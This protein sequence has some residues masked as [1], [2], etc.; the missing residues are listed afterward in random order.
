MKKSSGLQRT[1][2]MSAMIDRKKRPLEPSSQAARA[3][4]REYVEAHGGDTPIHT[5]LIANNG[6]AATKAMLSLREFAFDVLG[7]SKALC[8]VAMASGQ[9]LDANAEFVRLAD[10]VVEVPSG[11]NKNNYANVELIIDVAEREAVDAVWPG[12]GHASEYP[13]LP[14][15]LAKRNIA[16]IGPSGG[17]MRALGDKIAASILA[18]TARV[19]SIPWSGD[20]ITCD[21]KVVI[22]T[23]SIPPELFRKAMVTTA[24]EC[25]KAA[26]R[27]GYPV[28]LK[29][30]EGGGGKG[31]RM[32]Q[33]AQELRM[34]FVQVSNEVPGSPM[35]LMQLC[36]N[37]RHL[38]VQ[39]VG[40][41][42][43][44]AV[45]LNGRDCSTQRRFQKIFE[46][47]PAA[48]A[49][50][51]VFREMELAAM[52]LTQSIGYSGAG[53]VEYLY[54]AQTKKYYFLELNPRL[55]VEHPCTEGITD[56][57]MPAA[58][59]QVAMGIPLHRIPHIR[60][61]YGLEDVHGSSP[62]DFHVQRYPK[63]TKHI[64]AAR[65]TAENPDEGFKPTSGS[66]ERC[67]FQSN[68]NVWGYFSVGANGGIHE[69]ADSQFGH[70]FA[71][72]ATREI[73][74][75]HL[76]LALKSVE[77]RGAIRNPVEYLVELLESDA[78]KQNEIH[79]GWLDG[80][81]KAKSIAVPT[82]TPRLVLAAVLY[83]SHTFV[84]SKR[85]ELEAS[86][87]KGQLSTVLVKDLTAFAQTITYEG[88]KYDFHVAK[89]G[90]E[91]FSL[92]LNGQTIHAKVREQPD[93]SL[94][95][96]FGGATRKV[97]GLEEPLG[98]R[99]SCDGV[100]CL[101]PT[102]FDPSELRT[103]V[104]GKVVRYL[105]EEGAHLGAGQPYVE[106]EAMKM[107]MAL[108]TVESG[109]CFPA[110][111]SGS[112]ISAGD[113]LATLVLSDPSK[114]AKVIP[115]DGTLDDVL[116]A[117]DEDET[118]A[119]KCA[120][121]LD[122]YQR[123]DP[124][125]LAKE[126]TD[127]NVNVVVDEAAHLLQRYLVVESRYAGRPM[128]AVVQE[129][130]AEHKEDLGKAIDVARA[131]SQL[132][133]RTLLCQQVLKELLQLYA[134]RRAS[135]VDAAPMRLVSALA[136]LAA[137]PGDA[138]GD[139]A[140]LALRVSLVA[141]DEAPTPRTLDTRLF[142]KDSLTRG[143]ALI[144][145]ETGSS[146]ATA[147]LGN[148]AE[149]SQLTKPGRGGEPPVVFVFF[150]AAS[151]CFSGAKTVQAALE[152]VLE[153][154]AL[155]RRDAKVP[156][157]SSSS[158]VLRFPGGWGHAHPEDG[159]KALDAA[160]FGVA[161]RLASLHV[162]AL[163]VRVGSQDLSLAP[164]TSTDWPTFKSV[165]RGEADV[166]T[167]S[168]LAKRRA[169]ARRA[170]STFCYDFIG[171]FAREVRSGGGDAFV[172]DELVWEND[173]EDALTTSTRTPGLNDCGMVAWHCAAATREYPE[174]REFV[175]VANDV[176]FQSGSFGV[177]EDT[178]YAKASQ[179]ARSQ[180]L[181]Q[182]Y[183][184]CNS[185]ARIGLA[186]ELKPKFRVAWV[187][188][189][190]PQA[191]HDYLYLTASDHASL[192]PGS[193]QGKLVGDRFVL[194]AV[195]GA[196]HGIGVE[197]LRGSGTIAGE[198]SRAYADAFT[199]SYVTGRS[200]G[201]GAYLNRLS[202]RVIQM[203]Q[204]PIILTG[205]QALNK[206]LG[207]EVYTSQDQLGGPQVMHPNGVSHVTVDSDVE[208]V[209]EIMR[210]LSFVPR[211]KGAPPPVT[212]SEDPI[213]RP[214]EF[215]PTK[216]PYDPRHML[217][218]TPD[219][220]GFLDV[221]S[222]KEYLAG[223]GKS[224]VVGRGR[225]GG[226][227]VGVVAVE[228]RLSEQRVPADPANPDST[229]V[230]MPQAGQVWFPDSAYKTATAIRDF[231]GENLPTII[232]ANWRGFSG[233]TRDMYGEVLK[234]GAMIVDAL[235]ECSQPVFVYVPP[236]GELRGGAWVVVDPTINSAKMEMYADVESRGGILEPPGICEIKFR[237]SERVKTM[238]RLDTK[239]QALDKD[240]STNEEAIAQREE[241][242]APTYLGVAHE[243]AD[244]H[245]RAGRMKAKGVIRDVLSWPRSRAYLA[246]R[247]KRRLAEDP[248]RARFRGMSEEAVSAKLRALSGDA[249]D[250]DTAFVAWTGGTASRIAVD[251]AVNEAAVAAIQAEVKA[252][253]ADLAP[254]ARARA[255][256]SVVM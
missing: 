191:G 102:I 84:K 129:L 158:V 237:S 201:I 48:I 180:G 24:D 223:W 81:L 35:F 134:N 105:Q 13:E 42:H 82:N 22:E 27:I 67:K 209:S 251:A 137:L 14:D 78:F 31:I 169:T 163:S 41:R 33:N 212:K 217:N 152:N 98:L 219:A 177:R 12:W 197:N 174:G 216:A 238:H 126:L 120:L 148:R 51:S 77:I 236:H 250:D 220:R 26:E 3:C 252:L 230:I 10:R 107:I 21:P 183:V 109:K 196:T 199:L 243:F 9:D 106:V 58:Q 154:L 146:A 88:L 181:P 112:I 173:Q 103:D 108:K 29:A 245:D 141:N 34:N 247:L 179:Y 100:T 172:A 92:V 72:G 38:E 171:L 2:S 124:V 55:Q 121:L 210:W 232:F 76:V 49:D 150:S 57:N 244:L 83:R 54:H 90:P 56:V 53:T 4:M 28:M 151:D 110:K 256:A 225:L 229:E 144:E 215:L 52:R 206:L 70:I 198:T 176:T 125:T 116:D 242:L 187:D 114:V 194:D 234:F 147:F 117:V 20:G 200:V 115:F 226:A 228:T 74:R 1:S 97:H 23:G 168:P 202:Q 138:Y 233:G 5:I 39:I 167:P 79:T 186:D 222:F 136:Q 149:S 193:V 71:S 254:S 59:L 139:L 25:I 184:A 195:V 15:G 160:S 17:P 96:A 61:F 40:D 66:I 159:L 165:G 188:E 104:T 178:L 211:V 132:K 140:L 69:F 255:L 50:P 60:R 131:H 135:G 45:A 253:V 7:D 190:N 161:A 95:C 32:S 111:P 37:A 239:L 113:L 240:A 241:A 192:P 86:L 128:D 127:D 156:V 47:A 208:G 87:A 203:K 6:M 75:R 68:R 182:I 214:V 143:Y 221:G 89:A 8:F 11:S 73:A 218:G 130:V 65:I 227:P 224:V 62:I 205:Y 142:D 101:M 99:V 185:G 30:S 119:D 155:A 235:V 43:G 162:D 189:A 246:K 63:I 249:Y 122:G 145:L 123:G 94:L 118:G 157:T 44:Q 153:A 46:E 207:R 85:G 93:G 16:F 170:G 166:F 231:S 18:Q 80:I 91:L 248:L 164:P 175:V 133:R 204:G 213:D 64:I 36:S 19:S